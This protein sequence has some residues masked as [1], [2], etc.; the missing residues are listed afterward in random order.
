MHPDDREKTA[1]INSLEFFGFNCM[2]QGFT[3]QQRLN[4][5]FIKATA[6]AYADLSKPYEFHVDASRDGMGGV[7]SGVERKSLSGGL[8]KLQSHPPRRIIWC[9]N[10][11]SWPS[12][13][14]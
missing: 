1:F 6:L 7:I 3:G 5:S 14:L 12:S 4:G 9:I 13:G 10:W 11:S 8:C 2:L